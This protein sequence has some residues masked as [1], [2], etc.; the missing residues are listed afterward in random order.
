[1]M[2]NARILLA[3][4][5]LLLA[6]GL[7]ATAHAESPAALPKPNNPDHPGNAAFLKTFAALAAT[8][9][10]MAAA[11]AAGTQATVANPPAAVQATPP[12][13]DKLCKNS[14]PEVAKASPPAVVVPTSYT[15]SVLLK[16][17]L[18]AAPQLPPLDKAAPKSWVFATVQGAKAGPVLPNGKA[19][20]VTMWP[21]PKAD[22]GKPSAPTKPK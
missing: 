7:A 6:G 20:P 5:C 1:M 16:D 15:S 22:A 17:R 13:D 2:L 4:A 18:K 9:P 8:N 19:A 11:L 3:H 12:A 14:K 10:K 21:L